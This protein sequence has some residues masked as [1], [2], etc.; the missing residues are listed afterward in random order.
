VGGGLFPPLIGVVAGLVGTRI[1]AP[2]TRQPTRL[3]RFLASLWPWLL[4][5]F[6]AW[7]LGQFIVG[8]FFNDWLMESGFFSPLLILGLMVLSI[9]S[10]FAHDTHAQARR[11]QEEQL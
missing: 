6:F 5:A 7:M 9:V 4:V 11:L 8:H 10:A 1:N 3:T 2:L